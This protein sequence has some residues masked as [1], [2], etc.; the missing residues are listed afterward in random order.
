MEHHGVLDNG[1]CFKSNEFK[2]FCDGE[3]TERI[4]CTPNLLTGTGLVERTI[5]T[6]KSL[7]RANMADGLIF[8]DGVQL[9]IKKLDKHHTVG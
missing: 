9:A 2:Q 5:R 6:K 8:E 1:S 3:N 7:T 4:R